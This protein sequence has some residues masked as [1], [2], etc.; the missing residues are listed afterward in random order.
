MSKRIHQRHVQ[1][2][3]EY[4]SNGGSATDAYCKVYPKCKRVSAYT[5]GPQLLQHPDVAR[6]IREAEQK[7]M[8]KFNISAERIVQELACMA[9]LDIADLYNDDGS[10]K[11]LSEMPEEARRALEGIEVDELFDG[12]G[13]DREHVGRTKKLKVASKRAALQLL[14]ETMALFKQA[15]VIDEK[16]EQVHTVKV[17]KA[18]LDERIKNLT[19]DGGELGYDPFA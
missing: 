9:F 17:E 13:Q 16:S 19:G 10:L 1:F 11:Q 15:R 4:L 18:D 3:T 8:E 5:L 6:I 7:A 14:G 12:F 2:A